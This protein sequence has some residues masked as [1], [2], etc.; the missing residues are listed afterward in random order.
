[1]QASRGG[2]TQVPSGGSVP[3][4]VLPLIAEVVV[5]EAPS[6]EDGGVRLTRWKESEVLS[7]CATPSNPD[8]VPDPAP[9]GGSTGRSYD[10]PL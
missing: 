5:L 1:M 6:K 3:P 9:P 10:G 2:H 4:H 8:N 7:P